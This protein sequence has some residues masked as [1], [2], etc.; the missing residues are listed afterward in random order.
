MNISVI[1]PIYN[2]ELY[3]EKCINS[4]LAQTNRC[5]ELVLVDDGSTDNSGKICETFAEKDSRVKVIHKKNAGLINARITGIEAAKNELIS[6]VDADDWIDEMFLE[7]MAAVLEDKNADIVISGCMA[8]K[9]GFSRTIE[10][11]ISPGVYEGDKL[12]NCFFPHMLYYKGFYEFGVMPYMCNKMFRRK[13]LKSCYFNIDT[14]IYDGEDVAVVYPYLLFSKKVVVIDD[15]MYHYRLHENS[16]T[17]KRDRGFYENVSR[18]YLHLNKAF[19][20]SKHYEVMGPQLDEY[21]RMMIWKGTP[22]EVRGKTEQYFF[23]F[24]RVLQNSDIILYGAGEVGKKYYQQI[25]RTK[26]CRIVS[27]VDRDY[28]ELSAQG[29]SVEAPE[30]ILKYT[31][32]YIV[33]ANVK[34]KIRNEIKSYLISRGVREEMIVMG[35]EE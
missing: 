1:V 27:W 2:G 28:M 32:D 30:T 7:R 20:A 19:M 11:L 26:Y 12:I 8:E 35:E 17:N 6:F 25:M 3:V 33:I 15:P 31:F 10:N 4:I 21:M 16:M 14:K 5:F 18:L 29:L 24:A 9:C 22:A 13:F 23:P 34:D